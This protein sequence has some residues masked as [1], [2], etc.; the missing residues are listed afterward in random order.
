VASQ[1]VPGLIGGLSDAG[2]RLQTV[3]T[4]ALGAI[5]RHS[6]ELADALIEG[7]AIK[8]LT[9][10]YHSS[11]PGLKEAVAT[12]LTHIAKH[13]PEIAQLIVDAEAF[14]HALHCLKDRDESVRKASAWLVREIAKHTQELSK[15]VIDM[16]GAA[17]LVE[18]LKPENR[19]E[20][21]PAI[22]AIGYIASYSQTLTLALMSEGADAVALHVLVSSNDPYTKVAAV[23]TVGQLGKH[24]P[25]QVARL[26]DLN[27]LNL[28]LDA[29][30]SASASDD[31]KQKSKRALKNLIGKCT[32]LRVIEKLIA[33]APTVIKKYLIAQTAKLL[34]KTARDLTSFVK[35]GALRAVQ[36]ID[37]PP[38]SQFH[39]NIERINSFFSEAATLYY[40]PEYEAEILRKIQ[41]N[42]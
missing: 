5:A 18:Y 34:R 28:W 9:S 23:W 8:A 17:A 3:L 13:A 7:G 1:A 11:D 42:Q 6:P 38:G 40:K 10:L 15:F 29:H 27:A 41:E 30:T 20:P 37:A 39:Q 12:T 33:P 31:L 22:M 32:N 26:A 24:S 16:G 19:N 21:T 2:L 36:C 4:R 35:S 14:P 25:Q